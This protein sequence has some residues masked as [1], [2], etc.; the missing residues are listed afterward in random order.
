MTTRHALVITVR[1]AIQR[2][3]SFVTACAL[4]EAE[5]SAEL[6]RLEASPRAWSRFRAECE[7]SA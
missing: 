4:A 6:D 3:A 7:R 1:A 5:F 2:G